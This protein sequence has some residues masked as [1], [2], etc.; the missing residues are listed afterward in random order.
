MSESCDERISDESL[1]R[2][3][4]GEKLTKD[5]VEWIDVNSGD[6]VVGIYMRPKI[7]K[8]L[9]WPYMLRLDKCHEETDGKSW[10]LVLVNMHKLDDL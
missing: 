2:L 7:G 3:K 1:A 4:A 10:E 8:S 5:Q 6:E 9:P